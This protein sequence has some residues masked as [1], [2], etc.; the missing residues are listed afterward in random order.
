[1][2]SDFENVNRPD[3]AMNGG[4]DTAAVYFARVAALKDPETYRAA[5]SKASPERREK[6]ERLQR[7]EDRE[8]SLAAEL[9]LRK[10]LSD[11]GI[12]LPELRY[13]YGPHG[14]PYLADRPDFCFS[15]SHSGELVMLS[16]AGEEV[17]C[18]VERIAPTD[19][20][21]VERFFSDAEKAFFRGL[22]AERQNESFFRLWT[23]KEAFLKATGQGFSLPLDSF[24]I[25]F[26]D[27]GRATVRQSVD[28]K[29][30]AV[31]ELSPVPGYAAAVSLQ[32]K[33]LT[34]NVRTVDI[35]DL[36]RR[37]SDENGE[38]AAR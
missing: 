19:G 16:S 32:S 23:L 25:G 18:D 14:K 9:L 10:A 1:M 30:Y 15:I 4:K 6:T 31:A 37:L 11:A 27:D 28:P 5:L 34:L 29:G 36:C 12:G 24:S 13:S 17:G 2:T 35:R 33:T 21:I 20:R 7:P 26:D 38:G 3:P 8:R 22:P